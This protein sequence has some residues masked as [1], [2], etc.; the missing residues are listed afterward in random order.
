[1]TAETRREIGEYLVGH[2]DVIED[3]ALYEA[4]EAWTRM[5]HQRDQARRGMASLEAEVA[6]VRAIHAPVP[7]SLEDEPVCSECSTREY[8]ITWP[9]E[10]AEAVYL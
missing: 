5:R 6:K 4:L 3:A 1:M 2:I 9:C 8:S 10:T 7:R